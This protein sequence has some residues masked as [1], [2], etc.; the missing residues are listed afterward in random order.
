VGVSVFVP[1][2]EIGLQN[3]G[4]GAKSEGYPTMNERGKE[5]VQ[6]A[7]FKPW[8]VSA[9]IVRL[10]GQHTYDLSLLVA[11]SA[12]RLLAVIRTALQTFLNCPAFR[13]T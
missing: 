8:L 2:G 5:C 9:T 12:Q 11:P 1:H 4:L 10:D 13:A 6:E 7:P 3:V